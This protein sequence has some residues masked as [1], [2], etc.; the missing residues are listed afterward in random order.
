VKSYYCGKQIYSRGFSIVFNTASTGMGINLSAA[1]IFIAVS[2]CLAVK[3]G[4]FFNRLLLIQL[5][6]NQHHWHAP[7]YCLSSLLFLW[8]NL[9]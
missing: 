5:V 9:I 2:F 4:F 7:V 1:S 8:F 3:T 6:K